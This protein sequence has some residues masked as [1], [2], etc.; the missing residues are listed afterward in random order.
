MERQLPAKKTK[1]NNNNRERVLERGGGVGGKVLSQSTFR[2]KESK[3]KKRRSTRFEGHKEFVAEN[4]PPF[5]DV[6][7]ELFNIFLDP[8][9]SRRPKS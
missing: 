6:A 1:N 8:S 3:E 2:T 5:S 4:S 7:T 9:L